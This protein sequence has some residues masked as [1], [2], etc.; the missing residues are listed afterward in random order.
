MGFFCSIWCYVVK[1]AVSG[2]GF[3]PYW[4]NSRYVGFGRYS[5]EETT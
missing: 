3:K 4:R 5:P 2:E 1:D